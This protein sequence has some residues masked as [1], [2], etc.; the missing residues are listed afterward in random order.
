M[1]AE[2]TAKATGNR[3]AASARQGRHAAK[4]PAKAHVNRI[5]NTTGKTRSAKS[6]A[7]NS[8][9][10]RQLLRAK[11]A[12][13]R[14][15]SRPKKPRNPANT[16]AALWLWF[17]PVGL[18]LMWRGSCT[19]K[20][21]TKIAI[22]AA[23][24]AVLA[25][26]FVVPTPR[27]GGDVS[28]VQMVADKP[29]VEVYGPALPSLIVPGYTRESTGSIII[30]EVKNDVHYVYAADGARCYHEY[31]CKFAFASSQR[32]T[33]YEAYHLGFEPCGRCKPPVYVPGETVPVTAEPI[34]RSG[35]ATTAAT[36]DG[37]DA[38]AQPGSEATA[39]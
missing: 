24:A 33:V 5:K 3:H 23:M 34:D 1:K 17:F 39:S 21:G 25:A 13:K 36:V 22:T 7:R 2:K 15:A 32:L 29:S 19:W 20:R 8:A 4:A 35:A 28:G 14:L 6:R 38:A 37:T 30:D 9:F 11:A 12:F 26:I 16:K 10:N 27:V 31:E 18:S